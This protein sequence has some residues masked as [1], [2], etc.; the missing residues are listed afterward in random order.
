MTTS[1]DWVFSVLLSSGVVALISG[2]AWVAFLPGVVTGPPP[3]APKRWW[4]P[5]GRG[6]LVLSAVIFGNLLYSSRD[7]WAQTPPDQYIDA[8]ALALLVLI[9]GGVFV[10]SR[11]H[12]ATGIWP[13]GWRTPWG[14]FWVL[15]VIFLVAA[16][17]TVWAFTTMAASSVSI[18]C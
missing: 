4:S 15:P 8:T 18:P 2:G 10:A 3:P 7:K 5:G 6:H 11:R 13:N 12:R 16:G 14:F 1:P 9:L 17:S